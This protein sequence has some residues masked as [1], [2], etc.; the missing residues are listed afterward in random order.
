MAA[1][2]KYATDD[3]QKDEIHSLVYRDS[4]RQIEPHEHWK[5]E[6]QKAT[7]AGLSSADPGK[8]SHTDGHP[9]RSQVQGHPQP[10]IK[11]QGPGLLQLGQS[12]NQ[13][14]LQSSLLKQPFDAPLIGIPD[15]GSNA[16]FGRG[17]HQLGPRPGSF[18]LHSAPQGPPP[19][20]LAPGY[21]DPHGGIMGKAPPLGPEVRFGP[22]PVRT[23]EPERGSLG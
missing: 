13:I 22:H 15:P 23:N 21:V 3:A 7:D 2:D 1:E 19:T 14:E 11:S 20:V 5:Q 9:C 12:F 4:S 10:M 17:P 8:G 18:E 16:H 6:L